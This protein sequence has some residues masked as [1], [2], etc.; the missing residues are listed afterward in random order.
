M[1]EPR[2]VGGGDDWSEVSVG[3]QHVCGVRSGGL[4][5][6]GNNASGALGT[7]GYEDQ[8]VPARKVGGQSSWSAIAAGGGH[9]C[10]VSDGRLAC[11]GANLVGQLGI[12][13][14]WSPLPVG[15][16]PDH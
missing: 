4:S 13:D 5:C 16:L 7:G 11:W 2:R 9:T 3:F 15:Q 8:A 12:V 6:W 10:G 14:T 1:T